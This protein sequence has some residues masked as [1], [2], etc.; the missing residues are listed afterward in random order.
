[1]IKFKS[2]LVSCLIMGVLA[3]LLYI[4]GVGNIFAL[5]FHSLANIVAIAIATGIV[6]F[7]KSSFTTPTGTFAGVK[8][9]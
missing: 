7:I 3:G 6:S 4:I 8:I 2:A 5:D 9:K 1:M